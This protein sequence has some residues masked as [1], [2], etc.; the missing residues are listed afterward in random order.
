MK[1][2]AISLVTRKIELPCL[3][4]IIIAIYMYEMPESIRKKSPLKA[5]YM[6]TRQ[7]KRGDSFPMI[8]KE[9][10]SPN[11][12]RTNFFSFFRAKRNLLHTVWYWKVIFFF[13]IFFLFFFFFLNLKARDNGELFFFSGEKLCGAVQL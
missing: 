7:Y 3:C 6:V 1:C 13:T 4:Q 9:Y 12:R 8:P 10:W 11:S 5:T 2:R